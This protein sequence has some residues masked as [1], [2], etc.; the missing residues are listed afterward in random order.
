MVNICG[1]TFARGSAD[2]LSMGVIQG[3][4]RIQLV[5]IP[6][7]IDCRFLPA[8][9]EATFACKIS[10]KCERRRQFGMKNSHQDTG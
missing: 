9:P 7:G 8:G 4:R 6:G 3:Q 1:N 2:C 10:V 5:F